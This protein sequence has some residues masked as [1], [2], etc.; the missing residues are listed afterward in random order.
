[1]FPE[2]L[3]KNEQFQYPNHEK[4]NDFIQMKTN[5]G[6]ILGEVSELTIL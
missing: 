1:M 6:Y 5:S 3:V 4:Y 2:N